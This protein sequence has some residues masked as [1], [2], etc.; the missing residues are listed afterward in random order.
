MIDQNKLT[1]YIGAD[2]AIGNANKAVKYNAGFGMSYTNKRLQLG[3]SV[4]QL[5]E[6]RLENYT[7]V[8]TRNQDACLYRHFMPTVLTKLI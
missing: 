7:G 1:E 5:L 4:A 8:L 2:P 3:I 6:S